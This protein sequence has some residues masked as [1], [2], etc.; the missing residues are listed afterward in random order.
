MDPGDIHVDRARGT[1]FEDFQAQVEVFAQA[2]RGDVPTKDALLY[3]H[4]VLGNLCKLSETTSQRS[5][6]PPEPIVIH[7]SELI[8]PL[9]IDGDEIR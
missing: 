9:I 4:S 1:A 2:M 5:P 8:G 6:Q 3:V 7:E